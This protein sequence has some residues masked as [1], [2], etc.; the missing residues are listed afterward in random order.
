M[1]FRG[2]LDYIARATERL[3]GILQGI[4]ADYE[5]ND[6]EIANL[7]KWLSM[8]E[9][10]HDMEPFRGLIRLLERCLEDHFI[11]ESE[12][13][14]IL[15]FCIDLT[16]QSSTCIEC[17]TTATRR[18]HGFLHGI[19]LDKAL[20]ESEVN[21]LNDFM[22]DFEDF[23][24]LWPFCDVIQ[25]VDQILKDGMVT[26][27][28]TEELLSFCN[29]FTEQVVQNLKINEPVSDPKI[30]RL[31]EVPILKTFDAL[32][33]KKAQ[34]KFN[35]SSFCFTGLARTGSRKKLASIVEELG[36]IHKN[37]VINN[38][39]YL[40][41]GAQSSPCWA[42]STYGRKIEK[43]MDNRRCGYYTTILH[44]NDFLKQANT[45]A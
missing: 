12:R 44:E 7:Y 18:L 39:D 34:I 22:Q 6:T 13:E 2:H 14:E 28:E 29:H 27:E 41:I 45:R 32:C 26:K 4:T 36:G 3:H 8:H 31:D 21:D 40:V 17:N 16:N 11:D 20:S 23:K 25:V 37:N 33:D 35:D 30:Q 19:S 42:Y 1:S 15:D 9:L 43:V 38:L 5:L 24:D 10:L